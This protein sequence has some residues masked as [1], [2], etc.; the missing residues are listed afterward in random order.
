MR[1]V[2]GLVNPGGVAHAH[3]TLGPAA[4]RPVQNI[5]RVASLTRRSGGQPLQGKDVLPRDGHT[6]TAFLFATLGAG[7]V[8]GG[9]RGMLWCD[10]SLRHILN[11]ATDRRGSTIDKSIN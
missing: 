8:V 10:Q 3:T 6:F 7:V 5:L 1:T 2:L 9:H 11:L 4:T